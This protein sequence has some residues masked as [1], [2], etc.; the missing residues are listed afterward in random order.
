MSRARGVKQYS[1]LTKGLITE[2]SPLAFPQGATKDELNFV[3]ESYG[4]KRVRRKGLETQLS[5][6]YDY[7]SEGITFNELFPIR[8]HY[9]SDR[10]LYVLV[11]VGV[12][13]GDASVERLYINVY[14]ST[15]TLK[16]Y[17]EISTESLD[18][19]W[20][21]DDGWTDAE[22]YYHADVADI[23]QNYRKVTFTELSNTKLIL[24]YNRRYRPIFLEYT[25]DDDGEYI[26][27]KQQYLYYRDF[28]I[29]G[30]DYAANTRKTQPATYSADMTSVDDNYQYNII[31]AG[32]IR[33]KYP[34][35]SDG[36]TLRTPLEWIR[37]IGAGTYYP[38][39]TETPNTWI[40][41]SSS[42]IVYFDLASYKVASP[43]SSQAAVGSQMLYLAESTDRSYT[44][45]TSNATNLITVDT[46][47]L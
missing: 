14:D 20:N 33:K 1:P 37:R 22:N 39:M 7:S 17:T 36:T 4:N 9:W 42:E 15:A 25:S 41:T 35:T 3:F 38:A 5:F 21:D 8:I 40:T 10:D 13:S 29:L 31:N 27:I 2:A 46:I 6:T 16:G 32:W 19:L 30:T 12:P 44:A 23:K 11:V 47:T 26:E 45:I 18:A 43:D 28:S 24:T 34:S